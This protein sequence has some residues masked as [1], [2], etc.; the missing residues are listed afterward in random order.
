MRDLLRASADFLP[1]RSQLALLP[2]AVPLPPDSWGEPSPINGMAFR[3]FIAVPGNVRRVPPHIA[4]EA[5]EDCDVPP[6]AH[7]RLASRFTRA[8][9]PTTMEGHDSKIH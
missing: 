3:A 6:Q 9:S 4:A 2:G 7:S 5:S 8:A 1:T